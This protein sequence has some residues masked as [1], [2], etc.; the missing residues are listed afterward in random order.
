MSSFDWSPDGASIAFLVTDAKSEEEEKADKE[1]RDWRTLD[2]NV[3]MA[4]LC[5]ASVEKDK[6]GKRASRK[7]TSTDFNVNS[8]SWSP[9]GKTIAFS[10]QPTPSPN[11]WPTGDISLV[12]SPPCGGPFDVARRRG[13]PAYSPDGQRSPCGDRNP[14]AGPQ[15]RRPR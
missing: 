1:K 14:P 10:Y 11:D 9:D 4:R 15:G 12:T 3:K 6:D 7:V 13:Q 5:V 8:F 2:E